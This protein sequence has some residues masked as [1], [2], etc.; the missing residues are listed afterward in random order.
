MHT[1]IEEK[2]KVDSLKEVESRLAEVGAEFLEEQFQTDAYFD[3]ADA[4]L[5]SSDRALRLRRQ[6]TG[7]KE[8]A[9]LTYKGPKEKS[10]FKKR[11]EI[12]VELGDGDSAEKLLLALGY[13]KAL[14]FEKKRRV[15]RLNDCVVSLD[16]LPLLG[17]FVE[18]EGPDGDRIADVQ[19][20][21]GLF[22]LPHIVE[23]YA[24]L[25]QQRLRQLGKDQ[26]Q[27]FL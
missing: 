13:E 26:R 23:S 11:Q 21:L 20:D 17:G 22:D 1:E 15:W 10:D 2:L 9:F 18:I 6:R 24:C 8:K 27:V 12:E 4:A 5:K 25:M 19:R 16:E 7:Q 14:V 3:N